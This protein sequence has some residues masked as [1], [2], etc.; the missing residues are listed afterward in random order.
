MLDK[1]LSKSKFVLCYAIGI[2]YKRFVFIYRHFFFLNAQ[3]LKLPCSC[4]QSNAFI[5]LYIIALAIHLLIFHLCYASDH[6]PH[7]YT[8]NLIHFM[9]E[10]MRTHSRTHT[11][12]T[13]RASTCKHMKRNERRNEPTNERINRRTMRAHCLSTGNQEER[14]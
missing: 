13:S 10:M 9:I 1:P 7:K 14:R 6:N 3:T 4:S 2:T 5:L 8:L 11:L 12:T